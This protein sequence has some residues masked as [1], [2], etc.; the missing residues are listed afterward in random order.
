VK[1]TNYN[2]GATRD[3]APG[4][5]KGKGEPNMERNIAQICAEINEDIVF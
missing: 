4:K 1:Y 3:E 2:T 5:E